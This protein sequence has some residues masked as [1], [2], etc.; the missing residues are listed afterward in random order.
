MR[1]F[2][3]TTFTCLLLFSSLA[4]AKHENWVEVRSPNFI[5]VSNAGEKQARKSALQF[6]QIRAVFRQSLT[7][8]S[9]HPTPVITVVAVKDEGSMRELLPEYWAKG[10]S[11]PAGMFASRLDQFY[12]LV[13]LDAQGSHPYE[14]FYHEY[15]H[16][17]SL[18]YV[19]N[20]PLWLAEGLAEFFGHTDIEDK[21]VRMGEA[22]PVLL[23]ELRNNSLIPLSALFQV[24]R[25]SPYYNEANKTS[26]FYAESW[27]LTH[28]L[29]VGG[30]MAH[31]PML[32]AYLSAVD[33]GK[34]SE[35]AAKIAFG[36]LK[37]LQSDLQNYIGSTMYSYLKLPPA[38][39]DD[40]EL[41]LR[42]LS[43]A[44]ADAYRGGVAMVC[45]RYQDATATLDEALRLDPNVALAHQYLAA[46]Q[47]L[48]GQR[49][50][51]LASA[52]RAIALDPR[53]SSTRYMRAFLQTTG[54]GMG[55]SD[56]QTEDDLRQAIAIS[57]NFAPAYGLLAIY[58]A[59][60]DG[61][62]DEALTFAQKAIAF[63]PANSNY[64]LALAQVLAGQDKLDQ[65]ELAAKRATALAR[66][67]AEKA[68]AEKFTSYLQR[69][70]EV[71]NRMSGSVLND[72][73]TPK[74]DRVEASAASTG[75][76]SE[77]NG[78][79]QNAPLGA[80]KTPDSIG[81]ASVPASAVQMQ[82]SVNILSDT[83]GFDFT[84]YLRQI[85]EPVRQNLAANAAKGLIVGQRSLSV[86]F[87]I[88]KDG[89]MAGLKVSSSSGDAALDRTTED[90]VAALSPLP[91]LPREFKGQSVWLHLGISYSP[92]PFH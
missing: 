62:L 64:Q 76:S 3:G 53:N 36:D 84:P 34:S 52:S 79:V 15:Y 20:L 24:D 75:G 1:R 48:E 60:T 4:Q 18:P 6:E 65:A 26:I 47:F 58:L 43:E 12:A 14:N 30:Q 61:D 31:K 56:P 88:L 91:A 16:A 40:S 66:E 33:Q 37:P 59:A 2:R 38:K 63:E 72:A 32:I 83:L 13:Q 23:Q 46:T 49:D 81:K 7:I 41:K 69:K 22:D 45:G 10:H 87:A 50:K 44:E 71:Q 29:M 86:E 82:A 92:E 21:D 74:L 67:P 77:L 42:T 35:E 8:A 27:A 70:R 85:M 78:A 39:I 73:E 90:G 11:H 5:V 68:S 25:T 9:H 80:A 28:Y 17:I 57:P 19:P 51:A 54:S 55:F 89:K